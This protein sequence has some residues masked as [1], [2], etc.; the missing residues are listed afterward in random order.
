MTRTVN[1]GTI[2]SHRMWLIELMVRRMIPDVTAG[3]TLEI[4]R[5]PS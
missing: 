4:F 3:T 1:R 2:S 5:D